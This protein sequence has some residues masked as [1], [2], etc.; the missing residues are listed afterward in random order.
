VANISIYSGVGARIMGIEFIEVV[1]KWN[2]KIRETSDIF[3]EIS[4]G[5]FILDNDYRY[6][7]V[8]NS[9]C[10]MSGFSKEDFI[11][12]S[13]F[14][15]NPAENIEE[16]RKMIDKVNSSDKYIKELYMKRKD[17]IDSYVQLNA[18]KRNDGFLQMIIKDLS[19]KKR[20]EEALYESKELFERFADTI[21]AGIQII[22]RDKCIYANSYMEYLTGYTSDEIKRLQMQ[23]L[24]YDGDVNFIESRMESFR[25]K[26]FIK[27]KYPLRIIKKNGELCWIEVED[28]VATFRGEEVLIIC[29][30]DITQYKNLEVRLR[31]NEERYRLLLE[32]LPDAIFMREED[33]IVYCNAEGAKL[34]GIE[35]PEQAM[36]RRIGDF[37]MPHHDH[38]EESIKGYNHIH[39]KGYH[40]SIRTKLIRKID[41]QDIDIEIAV[42]SIIY[43]NKQCFIDIVRDV[44]PQVKAEQLEKDYKRNKELLNEVIEYDKL[45][46]EFFAN[47]SHELRTPLNVIL[48]IIQLQE[49]T[50]REVNSAMHADKSKKYTGILKQNCYRLL[51]LINNLLDITKIDSGFFTLNM[52]NRDIVSIVEDI[53]MSVVEYAKI[54]DIELIFDTDIE[55]K[56]IA[57]DPDKVERII[58][59]LL[60]NAVKFTPPQGNILVTVSNQGSF[61]FISVKDSG[62]GIPR[63]KQKFI[64]DRFVQV[65][66]SLSRQNEGSGIGLSLVKS[67]A[68]M[69][70]GSVSLISEEEKGSNFIVKLP[71]VLLDETANVEEDNCINQSKVER[72]SIEFSDI[73]K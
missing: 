52:K 49:V 14:E 5:V 1:D 10:I 3:D 19:D 31:E 8:N 33:D 4:E 45:K 23:E 67:L 56:V 68:E 46:T 64:F 55:E 62:I 18:R 47:L 50:Y 65:D 7:Y 69:H 30:H 35:S 17:R 70:G 36:E 22:S 57:V 42:R 44:S 27:T 20:V 24:V 51:R 73:Y 11:G 54:K 60:S 26:S 6:V 16:L 2:E 59:N 71:S 66:R 38:V 28:T 53:A 43:N 37:L 12:K 25:N 72:V 9:G 29:L 40:P 41:S 32:V 21:S 13:A 58:M 34:L 63:D 15:I 39:E 61:V 48:G